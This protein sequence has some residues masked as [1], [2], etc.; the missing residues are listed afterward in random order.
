MEIKTL[1]DIK[2]ILQNIPDEVLNKF[3]IGASGDIER[4]SLLCYDEEYFDMFDKY[5]EFKTIGKYIKNINDAAII[6]NEQDD[7]DDLY[8]KEEPISSEDNFE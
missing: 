1:L 3:G 4:I 5:S 2:N 6:V 8:N 7:A